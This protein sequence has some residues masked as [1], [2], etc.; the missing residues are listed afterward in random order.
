M[1]DEDEVLVRV[2][3]SERIEYCRMVSV[4]VGEKGMPFRVEGRYEVVVVQNGEGRITYKDRV[5]DVHK[6]DRVTI[7]SGVS[8]T[9]RSESEINVLIFGVSDK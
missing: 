4:E 7:P 1:Q 2:G 6:G 3:S 5:S 8:Y 9:V